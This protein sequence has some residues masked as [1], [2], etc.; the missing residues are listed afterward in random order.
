MTLRSVFSSAVVLLGI[1]LGGPAFAA[2]WVEGAPIVDTP[3]Y[4]PELPATFT[5][6][7]GALVNVHGDARHD[8]LMTGLARHANAA[9]PRL[10]ALLEVP[11]GDGIDV[12]V[13]SSEEQFFALQPGRAPDWAD[14]TA[15]PGMGAIFLRAPG[16][17]QPNAT[18]LEQVLDH[19]LVHIL[20]GRAFHPH[21]PPTWLQEGVAQVLAGEHGPS[22]MNAL[23]GAGRA[24][25]TLEELD[26][27]FPR[28][29]GAAHLAYAESADFIGW[30][31]ATYGRESI[32]KLVRGFVRGG[33]IDSALRL[34]TGKGVI[35]VQTEWQERLAGIPTSLFG[36]PLAESA[37]ALGGVGLVWTGRKRRR[38]RAERLEQRR[39]EEAVV[40]GIVQDL[41][42]NG[43]LEHRREL[44]A[45]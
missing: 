19:E 30:L 14:G 17:R 22:T 4:R 15:W 37:F 18:P 27:A 45:S 25:F 31:G 29:A 41:L 16:A 23:Q 42:R 28:D 8:A 1:L 24:R 2:D 11:L 12:Y 38:E 40:D 7:R 33:D 44:Q 9:A 5:T 26:R 3:A 36:M 32:A 43:Y 6:V 20:L 10:A 21:D 34:A 35:E 13:A 39:R